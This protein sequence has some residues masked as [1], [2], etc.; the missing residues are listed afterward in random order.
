IGFH[1]MTIDGSYAT[2]GTFNANLQHAHA[3]AVYGTSVDI[4]GVTMTDV[5]GDCIYFG[6][7]WY[8]PLV[9]SSGSVHDSTCLR[10]GRNAISVVA[11]DNILVQHVTTGSIGYDVF[12]VEPNAG[13]GFGSNSVRFDSNTIGSFAL[14]AYSV[15]ESG[16][17]SN[18]SFTNNHFVGRGLKV[19]VA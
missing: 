15:V 4:G 19:G 3:I 7:G 16:P 8:N 6:K 9:R 10:N 12:D 17:I 5:A 14:N 1:N 18:Q 2:G 13:S 11:G